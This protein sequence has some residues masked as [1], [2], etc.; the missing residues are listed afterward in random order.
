MGNFTFEEMNLLCIYNT[1]SRAGVIES[2][3]EMRG[4]L[5]AEETEL[6][7]LTDSTLRKLQAMTDDE[8]AELELYPD[9]DE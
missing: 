6:M 7:E 4:E 5:S 9:F 3:N 2:L 8:F 1:G